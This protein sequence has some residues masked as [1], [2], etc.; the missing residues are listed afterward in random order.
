M[1]RDFILGRRDEIKRLD[2][3]LAENQAQ[4]IA[5]YGRRRVGKTFLINNYFNGRFDFKLTGIYDQPMDLQ[6]R[7]F[8]IELSNQTGREQERPKDWME[9]FTLLSRFLSTRADSGKIVIFFDEM[10]WMDTRNSGFLS[11]FEWFWNSYGSTQDNLVM[12]VCGSATSWMRVNID[13]N[14]GGLYNRLTARIYLKPFS[15][16]ETQ[17]YLHSRGI[18]WSEYDIAECYMVLGGIPYYLSLLRRDMS[19]SQNVDNIFFRKRAELWDEFQFLYRSLFSDSKACIQIAEALSS[20]RGG[21]ERGEIIKKTGLPDNGRITTMLKD[22]EYSGFVRILSV[23]GCKKKRYQLSDYYSLFYF[24]FIRD[25]Y[26]RGEHFWSDMLDNPSRRAWEGLSFEQVCLDHVNQIKKALG[27]SGVLSSES[28][29]AVRPT[30]ES[31]G[32]QIDLLIDR[33][34]RV[35]NIC[36]I[37]FSRGDFIIDKNYD[38]ILRN[39]IEA[40]RLATS[41]QNTLQLTMITTYGIRPNKYSDLVTSSVTLDDLFQ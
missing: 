8:A 15:L 19:L 30:D 12:V 22:L 41:T 38:R 31:V 26:G 33:R 7:N 29:W 23:Y 11:A 14:R 9:A 5:V 3:C 1:N 21:L 16:R 40:F 10:P 37:K 35:T 27:I 39:K 13:E 24:R 25:N 2:V 4:L 18:V 20:S 32:A 6:L 28:T 34:D 17:E 36:E